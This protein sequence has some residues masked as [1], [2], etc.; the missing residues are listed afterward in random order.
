M[1]STGGK[2]ILCLDG[3]VS[4]GY[5]EIAW[6]RKEMVRLH[7]IVDQI[8]LKACIGDAETKSQATMLPLINSSREV[9]LGDQNWVHREERSVSGSQRIRIATRASTRLAHS[10]ISAEQT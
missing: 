1:I 2:L 5:A 4:R 10:A 9:K 6:Y 3:L 8:M 7:A